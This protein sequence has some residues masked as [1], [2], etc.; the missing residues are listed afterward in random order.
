M[1][2]K[3]IAVD[4]D[5]TLLN[6]NGEISPYTIE[7][8]HKCHNNGIKFVL[9]TGRPL[10]GVLE[11]LD[12]INIDIPIITFN[13]SEVLKGKSKEIIYQNNLNSNDSKYIFQLGLTKVDLVVAWVDNQLYVNTN[14]SKADFYANIAN[15]K[16]NLIQDIEK[17][18][19]KGS[20]KILWYDNESTIQKLSIEISSIIPNSTNFHTSRPYFLEFVDKN[21]SKAIAMQKLGEY[22]NINSSEMIA[23]GDGFNDISMIK[24]AGLGVAM[25]NSP[26]EVK[27]I[28]NFV[29]KTNDEDGVAYAITKFVL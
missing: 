8:I 4:I 27:N 18:F 23:I 22:F 1:N 2:Y 21:S 24:Y 15:T 13:G 7:C 12:K 10:V 26:L 14:N 5:G 3:L 6:S 20:N 29:T 16:F 19:I 9:S 25:G 11:L 28:S 17:L